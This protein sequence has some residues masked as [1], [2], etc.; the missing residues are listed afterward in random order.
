V[1]G[2]RKTVVW[3]WFDHTN[4]GLIAAL[5]FFFVELCVSF[6]GRQRRPQG[7]ACPSSVIDIYVQCVDLPVYC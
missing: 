1:L 3:A 2:R 4:V 5:V 7:D 6:R